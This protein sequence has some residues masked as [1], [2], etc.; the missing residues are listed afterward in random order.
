V[1][2]RGHGIVGFALAAMAARGAQAQGL[3]DEVVAPGATVASVQGAEAARVNPAGIGLGREWS[4]RITHTEEV[5][6]GGT[7]LNNTAAA[8]ATP[9]PFG[10]G[11]S[12]GATFARPDALAVGSRASLG[13]WGSVD[14]GLAWSLDRR[15]SVGIRTRVFAGTGGGPGSAAE[16]VDGR[17]AVDVGALWRPSAYGAFGVVARGVTG[18]QNLALGL[19]RSVVAGVAVRPVGT[20]AWTL[21]IDGAWAQQGNFQARAGTR[22]AVPHVGF[23]RAEGVW[24]F[25][26]DAW[27]AGVGLEVVWGR[28][29]AGGGGFFRSDDAAGWYASAGI[30]GDRGAVSL[31][32]PG[33]AVTVGMN[34]SPGARSMARL[35]L[36]LERLSRDPSVRGVI[37]AP[38]AEVGGLAHAEELR[39]AFALLRRRG[40]RVACHLTDATASTWYACAAVDRVSLDPAGGVRLQGLRSMRYF[41]GPALWALGV[42]TDFVRIG[43]WKSAPEQL[44][45]AAST[46]PA[47]EQEEQILD[48]T[49]DGLVA[50]I[51]ASRSLGA[52]ESRALVTAGPYTAREA[53]SR[54]MIDAVG[55]RE[56][57]ERSFA[58]SLGAGRVEL[59][60]YG[61]LR[62]RRWAGGRSVAIIHVDGDIVEGESQEIPVVGMRLAGERTVIEAIEAAVA[63]PNVGAIVLRVDSPGGSALASDLMWRAVALANRRKPVVASFGRIAA[64][65]GYYIGSAAREIVADPST[66]T[67]SIGIFYGK[68]DV[69]GLLSHLHVGVELSR[70]GERADMD[71]MFRP[72]TP[73]ERRF[74]ATKIGEF[75]GLFLQRVATGRHRTT[76]QV[77]AVGEGRVYLGTRAHALGLIDREGG[78]LTALRRARAL[79]GLAE[80]SDVIE[81]PAEP[82]GLLRTIAQLLVSEAPGTGSPSAADAVVSMLL[83]GHESLAVLRWMLTVTSRS[84]APMAMVEWPFAG[85]AG[86]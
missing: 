61:P 84:G 53:R 40:K 70:R 37:F 15:L 21:G 62:S 41:L 73:E 35:L 16:T 34:S 30:D 76:A 83:G 31:P 36:R 86:E 10:F 33:V 38:R 55:T 71:S 26:L 51:G 4:A 23:L 13:L 69:A 47:R 43:D 11:F 5:A 79:G 45:R 18:P 49:L 59:E 64:S 66:L 44:T 1:K 9:L 2:A 24:D 65:G 72:Y 82:G 57:A 3:G 25:G 29:S 7:A 46:G 56:S 78:L 20:D 50:G 63:S 54:G 39:E 22:L 12:V 27:R 6:R 32:T 75:Y 81:L 58:N 67:G 85:V 68:A 17:V 74:L 14:L 42:R 52:A 28:Y 19:D 80:D 8:W 60:D 77:D 48:D